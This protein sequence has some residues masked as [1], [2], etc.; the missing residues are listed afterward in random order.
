MTFAEMSSQNLAAMFVLCGPSCAGKDTLINLLLAKRPELAKVITNTTRE[1]R[2]GEED[3]KSYYFSTKEAFKEAEARSEFLETA[4]VHGQFYGTTQKAVHAVY[5]QGKL[6]VCILDVQGVQTVS[7]K[8]PIS[9][10][11]ITA[12]LETIERRVRATR[13]ANEVDKRMAS[14]RKEIAIGSGFEYVI[15]NDDERLE[16]V[17]QGLLEYYDQV[18]KPRLTAF[19]ENRAGRIE[20]RSSKT[21]SA[22]PRPSR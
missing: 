22:K 15:S 8:W 10:V 1:P 16:E 7:A 11:F 9:V 17:A 20:S 5:D 18:V 3:G 13:P 6:P 12:P 19:N 4:E 14:V 21:E 2:A